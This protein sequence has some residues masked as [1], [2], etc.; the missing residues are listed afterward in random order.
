MA[1]WQLQEAKARFS[2]VVKSSR[3]QGPQEITVHGRP[4]A[5]LLSK[6]D[7]DRLVDPK[8]SLVTFLQ[9]SPLRGTRLD[10]RRDKSPVRKVQL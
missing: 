9:R 5:V 4:A 7:Y 2:E 1:R 10:L 3:E 8:P 6:T